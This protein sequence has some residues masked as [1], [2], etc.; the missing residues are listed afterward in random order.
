M[1]DRPA[2]DELPRA[3]KLAE[4]ALETLNR[5]LHVEA[6]SGVALLVAAAA[7]LIWANSAFAHAYHVF[8]HLPFTFGLGEYVFSRSL[9]FWVNDG[10]MT[11]FFLVVGM[12]IRR[13]VHEGALSRFDQAVLPLIAATG[14]VV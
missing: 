2:V 13:E 9:H 4:Q 8:W 11:V 3:Q 1:T 14:G 6:V 10:L 12:E 7:A 5:F